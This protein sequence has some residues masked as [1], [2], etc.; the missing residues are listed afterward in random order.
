MLTFA[1]VQPEKK[2]TVGIFKGDID[3]LERIEC[4]VDNVSDSIDTKNDRNR[5]ENI[6][7]DTMESLEGNR[8]NEGVSTMTPLTFTLVDRA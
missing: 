2:N 4:L 5:K 6:I 1:V 7:S 3:Y 8:M